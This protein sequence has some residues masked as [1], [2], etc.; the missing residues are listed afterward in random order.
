M[1]KLSHSIFYDLSSAISS[2]NKEIF[3]SYKKVLFP[4]FVDFKGS[5]KWVIFS[6]GSMRRE[7]MM[8]VFQRWHY[9]DCLEANVISLFDPT[10][11]HYPK[12]TI[13]WFFGDEQRHYA[14]LLGEILSTFFASK[15]I[16]TK[17]IL[18]FGTS[19]GGIPSVLL[20]KHVRGCKV[21]IGNAQTSTDKYHPHLSTALYKTVAMK[22]DEVFLKFKNR[23]C[24]Y[25]IDADFTLYNAQNFFDTFHYKWQFLP[26][27]DHLEKKQTQMKYFFFVYYD[28]KTG[29]GP[30][31]KE[32]EI[33]LIHSILNEW[34]LKAVIKRNIKLLQSKKNFIYTFNP[35]L[36]AT[37]RLKSHL[38]YKLGQAMIEN[39]KSIK[40][41][42][43]MPYV[44]SYIKDKHKQEQ[45]AYEQSIK[46]N[47]SLKLPP[48][49]TYS[50][51]KEAL[52]IKEHLSY[53]LGEAW[54]KAY[55]NVWGGGIVKFLFI[56]VPR[57]KREFREKK[58]NKNMKNYIRKDKNERF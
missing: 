2:N 38:S 7:T 36:G 35:L 52:K 39:S 5:D 31:S 45:R 34:D 32:E 20:A 43:R 30:L 53:K 4:M 15:D 9:A 42:I 51:Y 19:A 56:D 28:E 17:N 25:D 48:L 18:F 12:L 10:L 29:H 41:Y 37:T 16:N 54:I 27:F 23:L 40:G 44:L 22:T 46:E 58:I 1:T 8:P 50:D 13:A 55:N 21:F 33:Y 14:N 11:F 49:E 47:P 24:L 3:I 26:Y 6:P 57:I